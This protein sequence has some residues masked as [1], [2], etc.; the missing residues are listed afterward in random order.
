MSYH[1]E[2]K[3]RKISKCSDEDHST[4]LPNF[5]FFLWIPECRSAEAFIYPRK[6]LTPSAGWCLLFAGLHPHCQQ[7][8]K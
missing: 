5:F 8:L 7:I 6:L 4:V 2:H 3:L 1:E